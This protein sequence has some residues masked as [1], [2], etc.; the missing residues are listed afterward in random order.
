MQII[1]FSIIVNRL[2]HTTINNDYVI[3]VNIF[4]K[5]ENEDKIAVKIITI[6]QPSCVEK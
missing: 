3:N 6:F 4:P 2:V 5:E 1:T